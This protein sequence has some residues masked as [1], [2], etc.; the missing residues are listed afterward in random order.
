MGDG[1]ATRRSPRK[2]VFSSGH[3]SAQVGVARAAC[4]LEEPNAEVKR[5]DVLPI[6]GPEIFGDKYVDQALDIE[7]I[8]ENEGTYRRLD[9]ESRP[10]RVA[11]EE[12]IELGSV[13]PK[14]TRV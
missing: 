9:A 1:S 2:A 6:T 8:I 7:A 11:K 5:S 13:R 3:E 12:G 14:V 10:R 4:L